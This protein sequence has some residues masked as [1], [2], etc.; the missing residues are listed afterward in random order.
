MRVFRSAVDFSA[1]NR[2]S[3]PISGTFIIACSVSV[4]IPAGDH[5]PLCG[6]RRRRHSILLQS[7]LSNHIGGVII[8]LFCA[9]AFFAIKRLGYIEFIT[10]GKVLRT[11]GVLRLVRQETYL[12]NFEDSLLRAN[13]PSECWTAIRGTCLDLHFASAYLV[14]EGEIFPGNFRLVRRRIRL[15]IQQVPRQKRPH[16]PDSHD[17]EGFAFADVF[18]LL[19]FAGQHGIEDLLRKACAEECRMS[20]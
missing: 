14:L 6:M 7:S 19:Y 20:A 11:G 9:L 8:L 17:Q 13:T 10:A 16:D 12:R 2:F 5:H 18:V 1:T 3:R 15:A 4:S